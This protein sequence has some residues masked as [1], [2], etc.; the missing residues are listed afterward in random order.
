MKI[1]HL[2]AA[3]ILAASAAAQAAPI[4]VATYSMPDG[5]PYFGAYYDNAYTG[6]NTG[7]F[8]SGGKGDLTDGVFGTSVVT[9][10]GA[11]SPYVLWYQQSPV[12]TFD[13]GAIHTLDSVTTY[14]KYYSSAAVYIPASVGVRFSSDG[15]SFGATQVRSLSST[16]RYLSDNMDGIY[17]LLA[18]PGV[19][20]YVELTLNNLPENAWIALA[21]VVFDGSLGGVSNVPEPAS[22]ALILAALAAMGL[23]GKRART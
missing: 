4:T 11:W 5:A 2:V 8:L 15:I 14:F 13:L 19:G 7:G 18:T 22:G 1:K 17:Q 3:A 23:R 21:E 10:Y 20:R 9:G 12:I 6:S 16:E